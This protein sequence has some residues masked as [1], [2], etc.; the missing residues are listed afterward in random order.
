MARAPVTARRIVDSLGGRR[1][2]RRRPASLDAL[3]ER[4]RKGLP[5]AALES[6]AARFGLAPHEL[7]VLLALAPRTMARR[8]A[9][10]RLRA[11]ESDRLFRVTRIAALSEEV[12]GTTQRA[13]HWLHSPNRALGNRTP[14]ALLD[15]DLGVRQVEDLLSRI[16]HGVYS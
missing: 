2:L 13:R 14:L 12:L 11:D 6:V 15:T 1:V 3:R 4:L 5:F 7:V 10:Q 9:E 8:K 16:A